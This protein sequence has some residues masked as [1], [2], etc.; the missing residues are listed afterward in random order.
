[1]FCNCI[2]SSAII[3]SPLITPRP[4]HNLSTLSNS[5]CSAVFSGEGVNTWVI[6]TPASLSALCP[7][8]VRPEMSHC[9][10][11][12]LAPAAGRCFLVRVRLTTEHWAAQATA[13]RAGPGRCLQITQGTSPWQRGE[14]AQWAR[15]DKPSPPTL[16]TDA[17]M[18]APANSQ[19]HN[20]PSYIFSPSATPNKETP[21]DVRG[22]CWPLSPW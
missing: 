8:Y 19:L 3:S 14:W 9:V 4:H 11:P 10:S 21:G 6:S 2:V 18:T 15:G 13:A 20:S 16:M 17:Q 22:A 1:M 5:D 7:L 12:D